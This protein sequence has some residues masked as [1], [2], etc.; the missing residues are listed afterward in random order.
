MD[1]FEMDLDTLYS[2]EQAMFVDY[3][4]SDYAPIV[5]KWITENQEYVDSLTS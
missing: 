1:N 3:D 5:A 4:G 2:L